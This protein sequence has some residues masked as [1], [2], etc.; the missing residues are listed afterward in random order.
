MI[1]RRAADGAWVYHLTVSEVEHEFAPGLVATCWGY[2]GQVH[3]PTFEGTE[4]DEVQIYVTNR[5]PTP[6][7]VHWHGVFLLSGMDGVGGLSQ[8]VIQ[9]GEMFLYEFPL[10]ENGM[11]MYHAHHDEM[12]QISDRH[13]SQTR[14]Y[15]R[16]SPRTPRV[17]RIERSGSE[18]EPAAQSCGGPVRLRQQCPRVYERVGRG[19]RIPR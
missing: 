17:P 9:P 16:R 6:T 7:T 10:R 15:C 5:L 14:G 8:P 18:L 4:G 13:V 3:G 11:F 1:G 12:T 2:S 19:Q